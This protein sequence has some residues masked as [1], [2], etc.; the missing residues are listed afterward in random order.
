MCRTVLFFTM[1]AFLMSVGGC[2]KKMSKDEYADKFTDKIGAEDVVI[3][4]I[5]AI[6][7]VRSQVDRQHLYMSMAGRGGLSGFAQ[8]RLVGAVFS[9]LKGNSAKEEVLVELVGNVDFACSAKMTMLEK[10][11]KL[12]PESRRNILQAFYERGGCVDEVREESKP[13]L[14][15]S[16]WREK[17]N[18]LGVG[19]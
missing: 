3:A 13:V 4:E 9:Q 11:K 14:K 2:A 17:M 18:K 16:R 5:E 7:M 15:R 6:R 8:V 1:F 10:L 12:R 19:G